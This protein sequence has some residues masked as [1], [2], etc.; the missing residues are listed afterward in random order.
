MRRQL[1][2]LA[3]MRAAG[4]GVIVAVLVVLQAASPAQA[5]NEL[6][7][8]NPAKGSRLTSAPPQVEL[9]FAERLDAR[10]TS[11]RVTDAKAKAVV[12]GAPVITGTRAKQALRAGLGVGTYTVA[13]RVVSV[14][15]HPVAGSFTFA[16]IG[17]SPATSESV[18]P[19]P[20]DSATGATTAPSATHQPKPAGALD[21]AGV[22]GL[23][24]LALI[25]AGG[26]LFWRAKRTRRK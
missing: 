1:G 21:G 17:S 2:I 19:G 10:Y 9:V 6:K 23:A 18:T 20:T 5:H 11:V 26:G 4:L 12:S 7:E 22:V 16:V 8:S 15:G 25:A 13:Y 3:S 14:D 24:L